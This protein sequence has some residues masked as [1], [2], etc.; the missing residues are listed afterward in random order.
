MF[1]LNVIDDVVG[2]I[3]QGSQSVMNLKYLSTDH[4]LSIQGHQIIIPIS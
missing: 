3:V 1:R 4:T 2:A